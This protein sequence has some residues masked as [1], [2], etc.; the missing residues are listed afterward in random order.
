MASRKAVMSKIWEYLV[1]AFGTFLFCAAWECFMTPNNLSSG[2]LTGLCTVIQYAT[3]GG[4]PIYLS[5]GVVNVILI[6]IAFF[7]LGGRFGIK[8]IFCI[9]LST[10]LF[11]VLAKIDAV[12][13]LPGHFLYVRETFMLPILGGLFEGLGLGIIL[14]WGGSTGGTDIVAMIINKYWP[15]SPGRFYLISDMFIITSILLLPDRQL[16]DMI[17][18][19][20]MMLVSA[21]MVDFV[22]MGTKQSVQLLVFSEKFEEI[23]DY[24]INTMER[25]VTVLN[26]TGWYT[27]Q[28]RK[29]LLILIRKKQLSEI[30]RVIKSIDD[31]AFVSVSKASSVFGEGFEEIKTG[32]SRNRKSKEQ[33]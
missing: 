19:Y 12:H 33:N 20:M 6:G 14:K 27:K 13:S 26:A 8:T 11:A 15:V 22:V 31:K 10:V 17:Y 16:S 4:I 23:A 5:Y 30:N 32:Y 2:G 28:D 1:L 29:V 25:G 21:P 3:R 7:V 18:G 9:G 24:I